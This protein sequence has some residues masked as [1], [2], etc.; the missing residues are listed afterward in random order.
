MTTEPSDGAGRDPG[1]EGAT[2][3]TVLDDYAA[4]GYDGSLSATDDANVHC[5]ACGET[6]PPGE[7]TALS[8]RRLEG[9]SDPAD[10][11]A[12][13]AVQCPRCGQ[14]GTMTLGYGPA[15]MPCDGDVLR[16]LDDRRGS[17]SLA[18]DSADGATPETGSALD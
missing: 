6:F 8:I 18:P 9:A 4:R 7:I 10:M 5:G 15:A 16:A 13:V 2:L 12:V 3:V 17:S 14:R 11:L 1:D